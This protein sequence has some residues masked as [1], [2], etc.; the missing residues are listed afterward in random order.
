MTIRSG[1]ENA[2]LGSLVGLAIGDALGLPVIGKSAD[3]IEPFT[4][5]LDM[6]VVG[7]G[8]ETETV[9]GQIS[10]KTEIALCMVESLTTNDGVLD[11]E[12]I[13]AR[14][15]FLAESGSAQWMT[16]T[17]LRG[18]E[19]GFE[20]DGLVPEGTA[21][22]PEASVAV[23]GVVIGLLHSIGDPDDASR[24]ADATTVARLTHTDA[25]SAAAAAYVATVTEQAARTVDEEPNW[26]LPPIGFEG[27]LA[28]RLQRIVEQVQRADSFEDAVLPVVHEGGLAATWGA[29]AGGIA[30]ARF[31][32]AGLPQSLIDDLDARIYLSMAAPWFYRTAMRKAGV[33]I[34]LRLI[35]NEFP[36]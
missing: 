34:D 36:G 21:T 31:G 23:R 35:E 15:N 14:L 10:D 33:A 4:S 5:Y 2:F 7:D 27:D 17:V 8:A 3:E 25:G 29:I 22:Q 1:N 16:E 6:P 12:N 20:H 32:A 30:G 19:L 13:N 26:E 9:K 11:P 28:D 24:N 18:I